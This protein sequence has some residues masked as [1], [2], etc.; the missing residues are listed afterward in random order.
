MQGGFC[1]KVY[2]D[3]AATTKLDSRV[4]EEMMPFLTEK[5]G[6]ASSIHSLGREAREAVENARKKIA[7]KLRC[8][9]EEIIFTSGGT[10][11]NNFALKGVAFANRDRGKHIIVSKIE[12]PCVLETAKWLQ[13]NGFEVEYVGVDEFGIVKLEELQQK[14]RKDT[15][16]VSVMHANNEIGTI[17]PIKE[18]GKLCKEVG[19]YFH[20]DACQSFTKEDIDVK[21][22]DV[23]LITVNAHKIHGPKGVGGLF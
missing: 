15:I 5:Y 7:K 18:I 13:K 9:A 3:N 1:M 20:T 14:I 6:N 23:D 11:A 2:L 4:L 16:L 22:L 12:H 17:Q 21:K 10:E 8:K 19:A